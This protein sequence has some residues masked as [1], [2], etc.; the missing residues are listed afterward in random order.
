MKI[1]RSAMKAVLCALLGVVGM[2]AAMAA[3]KVAVIVPLTGALASAG[4]EI[5]ATSKAWAARVNGKSGW[6]GRSA[7]A[8]RQVHRRWRA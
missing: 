4:K 1:T 5:E 7:G 3:T 2:S 8:G 6:H